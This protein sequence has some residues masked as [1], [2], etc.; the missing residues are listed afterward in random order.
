VWCE[1]SSTESG[2][3]RRDDDTAGRDLDGMEPAVSTTFH[4]PTRAVTASQKLLTLVG[5]IRQL[6]FGTLPPIEALGV[7]AT[8]S[9]S[10]TTPDPHALHSGLHPRH[11]KGRTLAVQR[12][13][14]ARVGAP[15]GA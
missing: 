11:R 12:R 9:A 13:P 7:S 14:R 4:H 1:I 5:V 2:R 3:S 8:R 15:A 6:A 10:T